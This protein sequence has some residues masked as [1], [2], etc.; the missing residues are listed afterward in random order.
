MRTLIALALSATLFQ[1][2]G[3]VVDGVEAA[4]VRPVE[5]MRAGASVGHEMH[6]MFA[7]EKAR[8]KPAELPAQF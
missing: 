8:A 3:C 2:S 1:L 6:R 7:D 4:Q 5:T